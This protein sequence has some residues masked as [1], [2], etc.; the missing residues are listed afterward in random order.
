MMNLFLTNMQLFTAQNFNWWTGVVWITCGL[1]WCF[2]QLFG[3]SFWRHPFTA[4]DPVVSKWCNAKF[5]QI[6]SDKSNDLGWPK[7]EYIFSK[8]S[9]L[10]HRGHRDHRDYW[11]TML[12]EITAQLMSVICCF[13]LCLSSSCFVLT[14]MNTHMISLSAAV[15]CSYPICYLLSVS[16]MS[17]LHNRGACLIKYEILCAMRGGNVFAPDKQTN[18]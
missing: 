11:F 16:L 15:P 7:D 18:Y 10:D 9:F 3:L 17:L 13:Y 8:F 12:L 1:L 4:E 5:L 2:Y 6:C 14:E